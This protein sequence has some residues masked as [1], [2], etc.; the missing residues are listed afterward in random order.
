MAGVITMLFGRRGGLSHIKDTLFIKYF[1]RL[2]TKKL[3]T[4][5]LAMW[6]IN[7]Q[8]YL[9]FFLSTNSE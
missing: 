4:L 8:I 5:P 6:V 9:S 3:A 2:A 7:T 1:N